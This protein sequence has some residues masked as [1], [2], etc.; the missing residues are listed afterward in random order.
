MKVED[1][2]NKKNKGYHIVD[3][4]DTTE[5]MKR[6]ISNNQAVNILDVL[7][8]KRW[9]RTDDDSVNK[10]QFPIIDLRSFISRLEPLKQYVNSNSKDLRF[11][12]NFDMI[13]TLNI[14]DIKVSDKLEKKEDLTLRLDH[15]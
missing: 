7:G 3:R 6:F 1:L 13:S 2:Y 8:Y 15:L 12:P 14:N 10:R 5:R 9:L 4:I 11:Y